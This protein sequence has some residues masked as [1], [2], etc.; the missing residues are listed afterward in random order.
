VQISAIPVPPAE[1]RNTFRCQL[2]RYPRGGDPLTIEVLFQTTQEYPAPPSAE[3]VLRWLASGAAHL[4]LE[5]D[6]GKWALLQRMVMIG[7]PV[8]PVYRG[9]VRN[10]ATFGAFIDSLLREASALHAFLGCEG[11]EEMMVE[12]G[13]E[14]D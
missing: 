8:D 7:G 4:A 9:V 10:A 5:L 3:E 12:A 14:E 6:L 2:R 1:R 11:F 13:I